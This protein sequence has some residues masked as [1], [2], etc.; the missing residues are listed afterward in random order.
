MKT[1]GMLI[2]DDTLVLCSDAAPFDDTVAVGDTAAV[3]N[4]AV[5]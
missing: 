4:A 1:S 5:I 3:D 2:F